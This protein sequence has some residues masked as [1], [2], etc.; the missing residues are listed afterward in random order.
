MGVWGILGKVNYGSSD[1]TVGFV[2]RA[3]KFY[4]PQTGLKV[5]KMQRSAEA[6][7]VLLTYPA[8]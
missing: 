6:A 1:L 4:P 2:S 7:C 8:Q 3:R 5:E